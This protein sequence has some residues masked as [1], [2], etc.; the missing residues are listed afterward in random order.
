MGNIL[1]PGNDNSFIR[2]VKAKDTRVFVDKTDFIE[3]TNALF[4]T[5]GNLI[6]VTRPRRFGKTVTAHMLSAY[7]SKGYA[8]QE[9]FNDLEISNKNSFK[10][11]L[12]KY[13][14]I[15]ID[16]NSIDGR[17]KNYLKKT[18]KVQGVESLVDYLE[19]SII[20]E[21]RGQKNFA[22]CFENNDIENT[23]LLEAL[24]ALQTDLNAQFIFIMDEWDLVYR[25]YRHDETLQKAFINLLK[26]LF[27]SDDGYACFALAYLTGILPIKKYNSQSALNGFDEYNMLAPG[28]FAKYFGFTEDEVAEIVKSPKC[29]ISHQ[30]LKEWYEGYKIK[31]VDIYNPNSVTK[32]VSRNECI[33][34]WSGTSSNEEVVRLINMNFDGIKQDI[35]NLIE[36][37]EIAFNCG[38]FQNDMVSIK[39]EDDILSLLVC[40]G[41]L[42]CKNPNGDNVEE[43]KS[44]EDN[45]EDTTEQTEKIEQDEQAKTANNKNRRIAYIPNAEIKSALMDIVKE[46][47][48]YERMETIERSENLLKAIKAL[49][50]N[51]VAELIQNVHNSP[52]V[53]IYD[54]TSESALTFCVITGLLWSTLDD[55][56]YHREDQAGKGRVD[57]VYEPS[58]KGSEPLILIEFKYGESAETALRQIKTQEYYKRYTKKYTKNIILVGINYDPKTKDHQCLIE[59]LD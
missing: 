46:Q 47:E 55:Y 33:S 58:V 24:S 39:S 16:M 32:A 50:G 3:K 6:A 54:Y 9:I 34:Y 15:Y 49:D 53:S 56:D 17:Y 42:G 7:Y 43:E 40:L 37:R 10:E 4:N 29:Q 48:W 20:K 18:K 59:K 36:G 35:L 2:L 51:K 52:S 45:N 30:D 28:D 19:Y 22:E 11:H 31:G 27:K 12:N 41:Y 26:D 8:G 5:D 1:N 13:D 23:G 14:V 38:R 57:L 44:S 21:L 25:E